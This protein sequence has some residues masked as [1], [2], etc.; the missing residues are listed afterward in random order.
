[1]LKTMYDIDGNSVNLM[2]VSVI[3]A[4]KETR[5]EHKTDGVV[6]N[7]GGIENFYFNIVFTNSTVLSISSERNKA[8]LIVERDKLKKAINKIWLK[9]QE[10]NSISLAEHVYKMKAV[11]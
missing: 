2:L 1:M 8:W 6:D 9:Q 4:I 10:I 5:Y 11:G 3:T 7:V